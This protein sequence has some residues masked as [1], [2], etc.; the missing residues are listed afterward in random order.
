M[1]SEEGPLRVEDRDTLNTSLDEAIMQA[2]AGYA[3]VQSSLRDQ[4][5]AIMAHDLRNPLGVA[6]SAADLIL[7][8][9][10]AEDVPRWAARIADNVGRVDGMVQDLLDVM[11]VQTG[12]R[13]QLELDE[14][15]LVDVVR[16]TLEHLRVDVGERLVLEA[17]E[18]VRGHFA[19]DALRRAVENLASNAVKYGSPHQPITVTRAHFSRPP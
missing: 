15:D 3:L 11:R 18:P 19:C 7:L 6:Q 12:A 13:L 17:A 2:C 8:Q 1:C 10:T 14:C 5:F 16:G 9:P 4:L